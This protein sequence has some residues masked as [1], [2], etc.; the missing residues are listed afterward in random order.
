ML[1]ENQEIQ[2]TIEFFKQN[3]LAWVGDR[4]DTN[5]TIFAD[6]LIAW[7]QQLRQVVQATPENLAIAYKHLQAANR[8]LVYYTPVEAEYYKLVQRLGPDQTATIEHFIDHRRFVRD[9]EERLETFNCLANYMLAISRQIT[10][11]NLDNAIGNIQNSPFG[12]YGHLRFTTFQ[13]VEYEVDALGQR[14]KKIEKEKEPTPTRKI[15]A[16]EKARAISHITSNDSNDPRSSVRKIDPDSP[17]GQH[18]AQIHAA[19]RTTERQVAQE[20][21]PI[22]A[23]FEQRITDSLNTMNRTDRAIVEQ[24]VQELRERGMGSSRI[25]TNLENFY[26]RLKTESLHNANKQ[27]RI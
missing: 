5:G 9:G 4:G 3:N 2:N 25:Y 20:Q 18:Q 13:P 24:H 16:E 8:P 23:Y 7:S 26:N 15:S 27:G 6:F 21:D 1:T 17:L 11:M 12:K 10:E 14:I 22:Q 19:M